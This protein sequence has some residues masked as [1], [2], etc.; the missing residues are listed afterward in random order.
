AIE[1]EDA[2]LLGV[3][4]ES[5]YQELMQQIKLEKIRAIDRHQKEIKKSLE[6]EIIKRYFYRGGLY[7]YYLSHDVA[8]AEAISV[9][10]DAKGYSSILK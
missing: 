4:M 8:I 6:D 5:R 2:T 1:D 9:L 10:K 3:E 7:K